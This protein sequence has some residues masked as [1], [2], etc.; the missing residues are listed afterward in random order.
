M[1]VPTSGA[2][3]SSNAANPTKEDLLCPIT[4]AKVS[5]AVQPLDSKGQ[6]TGRVQKV[7]VVM[8]QM[9]GKGPETTHYGNNITL[10]PPGEYR[11]EA[12]ANGHPVY[13]TVNVT[14]E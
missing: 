1:R 11:V 13:F 2:D 10:P 12:I 7:P 14:K 8:M 3:S 5:L 4:N 6:P 9:I